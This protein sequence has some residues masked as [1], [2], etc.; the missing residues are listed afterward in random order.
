MSKA[1]K[2]QLKAV[3]AMVEAVLLQI[4]D[5]ECQHP[6]EERIDMSTMGREAWMCRT[7]GYTFGMKEGD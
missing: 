1:L 5:G 6:Q 4:D 3:I 2:A 7:C